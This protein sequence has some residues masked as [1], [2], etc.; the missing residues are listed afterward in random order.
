MKLVFTLL[1]SFPLSAVAMAD[2]SP[3]ETL[4]KSVDAAVINGS[5]KQSFTQALASALQHEEKERLAVTQ[6]CDA[7]FR[8]VRTR[9]E[10]C[11][12][13]I[14]KSLAGQL[15]GECG[16]FEKGTYSFRFLRAQ[17]QGNYKINGDIQLEISRR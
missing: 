7:T 12:V 14:R 2:E 16:E 6:N 3:L 9:L 8:N 13:T 11:L 10:N 4:M 5:N 17:V 15:Q 1:V